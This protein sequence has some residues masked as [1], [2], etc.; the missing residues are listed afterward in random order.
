MATLL[1]ANNFDKRIY[2]THLH[3][4]SLPEPVIVFFISEYRLG[5]FRIGGVMR[6]NLQGNSEPYGFLS[7]ISHYMFLGRYYY[8]SL[9]YRL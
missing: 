4:L 9:E 6:L 2:G 8:I 5:L 7:N 1:T 3:V